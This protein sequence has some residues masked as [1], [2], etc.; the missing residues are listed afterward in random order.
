M[1]SSFSRG[2]APTQQSRSSRSLATASYSSSEAG[3]CEEEKRGSVHLFRSIVLDDKAAGYLQGDIVL[4]GIYKTTYVVVTFMQH[5][6]TNSI[7][8]KYYRSRSRTRRFSLDAPLTKL[9]P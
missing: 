2:S 4:H 1:A 6:Q 9:F 8:Y 7:T 5:T 3:E